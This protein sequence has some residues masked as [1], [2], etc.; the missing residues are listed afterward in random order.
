MSFSP[1]H[2]DKVDDICALPYRVCL[3]SCGF[4]KVVKVVR[5][6][7]WPVIIL[8]LSAL[9]S[10]TSKQCISC[11]RGFCRRFVAFTTLDSFSVFYPKSERLILSAP[12][13]SRVC[14]AFFYAIP[15]E[16]KMIHENSKIM[17]ASYNLGT[18]T[19]GNNQRWIP[20]RR[21]K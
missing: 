20:L 10:Q 9:T 18:L 12:I 16:W 5:F 3:N 2:F 1:K 19:L 6:S 21:Q 7:D 15:W 14:S 4:D 17:F 13:L 11:K 8:F